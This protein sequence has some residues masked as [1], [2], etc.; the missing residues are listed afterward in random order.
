MN[1]T[2]GLH[3]GHGMHYHQML[4]LSY[5]IF[6][7]VL[8]G[9]HH[10]SCVINA[11]SVKNGMKGVWL[12]LLGEMGQWG[13]LQ[14]SDAGGTVGQV[15]ERDLS[16]SLQGHLSLPRGLRLHFAYAASWHTTARPVPML[17]TWRASTAEELEKAD[18]HRP[19][20]SVF[21]EAQLCELAA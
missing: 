16:F 19:R 7:G 18:P 10:S 14:G 6:P 13:T 4:F 1:S 15:G 9:T 5:G 12:R 21:W 11:Q 20:L 17:Q 8:C 2:E 3:S